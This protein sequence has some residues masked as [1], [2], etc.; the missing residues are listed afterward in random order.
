[1]KW[2][3]SKEGL[4]VL[5]NLPCGRTL[6]AFDFDG[7]LTHII[8]DPDQVRLPHATERLLEKVTKCGPLAIVTGRS[9]GD[10]RK[11]FPISQAILIG[12]HGAEENGRRGMQKFRKICQ[13]WHFQLSRQDLPA[14][15]RIEDKGFSLSLHYRG[16]AKP[17]STKRGLEKICR[18][19]DPVARMIPGKAILSLLPPGAPNKGSALLKVMQK[20]RLE[21]LVYVGD[22]DTDEDVFA[23]D[24]PHWVSIR[25]G[26]RPKSKA[27]FFLKNQSE[28]HRLLKEIVRSQPNGAA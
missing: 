2:I 20:N 3:F 23:I 28:I 22:D 16:V 7:T 18:S 21:H 12:N 11:R 13:R 15:V 17:L 9:V 14:G 10:L 1:M 27:R 5:R 19:L 6:F 26:R 24:R 8:K 25:V 4:T